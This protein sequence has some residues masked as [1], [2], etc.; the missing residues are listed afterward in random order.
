MKGGSYVG[1]CVLL[2]LSGA[3]GA[4]RTAPTGSGIHDAE[5]DRVLTDRLNKDLAGVKRFKGQ[6]PHV[7][8]RARIDL[9]TCEVTLDVPASFLPSEL[10]E[11]FREELRG[12]E[13]S[14]W[15]TSQGLGCTGGGKFLFSGKPI[16]YYFPDA[17]EM[18][19]SA[20]DAGSP[21]NESL[22][23]VAAG[24][25]LYY[26]HKYNDWRYQRSSS[27]GIIE[28]E[29][30]PLLAEELTRYVRER[31][32]HEVRRVRSTSSHAHD[33]SGQPWWQVSARYSLMELLPD[34][35]PIWNS[36]PNSTR[37]DRERL[38]DIRSRPLYANHVGAAGL[39]NV[40]TNASKTNP[41]ARGA[42][43]YVHPDQL[44]NLPLARNMLCYMKELITAQAGYESF[45]VEPEPNTYDHGEN[46]LAMMPAVVVE[47]AFH[48]NVDD[49]LALQ[50]P[51]FRTAAMKGVE[52]GYRL[53]RE[54]KGC[55]PLALK[56]IADI[57]VASWSSKDVPLAFE[58]HPQYP[59]VAVTTAQSC[60]EGWEC[61]EGKTTQGD[62]SWPIKATLR[63]ENSNPGR[64]VWQTQ[65]ID[66]DGVRSTPVTHAVD[67]GGA[68]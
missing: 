10:S 46:R 50:D 29:V 64:I 30:T 62:A 16:E 27:N 48:T 36:L 42:R 11:D 38:E 26:H 56:P 1:C 14:I 32:G 47:A 58:G 24:H 44:Q 63:C 20:R 7:I 25:G 37:N 9:A 28:D 15:W 60:P 41:L 6:A 66:D 31:S 68:G 19:S 53:H 5:A 12:I 45:R 57:A 55:V 40:H 39:I 34:Q 4:A 35:S 23:I 43:V 51:V 61:R 3:A 59:V 67:C 18:L 22:T 33:G 52:K 13:N 21:R 49:A 17:D 8:G 54:G 65:L 2:M